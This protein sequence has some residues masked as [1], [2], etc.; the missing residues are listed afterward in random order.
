MRAKKNLRVN[1]I[2]FI[3]GYTGTVLLTGITNFL[4]ITGILSYYESPSLGAKLRLAGWLCLLMFDT[5][6]YTWVIR[7]RGKK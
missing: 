7:Y 2:K 5:F 4:M 6:L 1:K 3:A